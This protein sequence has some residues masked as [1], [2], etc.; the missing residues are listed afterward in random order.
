MTT[1]KGHILR[2]I[3]VRA[4]HDPHLPGTTARARHCRGCSRLVLAGYD[5]P[6]CACLA[7]VDPHRLTP[8][9]EAAAAVLGRMTYRLHG[10]PDAYQ[11]AYRAPQYP[12]VVEL[13]PAD[14]CVVVAAHDCGRPPL[15]GEPVPTRVTPV[16]YPDDP[17]F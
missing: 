9:L 13:V 7:I 17:P 11:L 10:A 4:G 6:V 1:K 8:D 12:P 5:A 14:L 16:A 2:A 15:P 3:A